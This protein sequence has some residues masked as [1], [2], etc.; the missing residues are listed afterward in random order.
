MLSFCLEQS[1]QGNASALARL[2]GGHYSQIGLYLGQKELPRFTSLLGLCFAL[3]ISP[4][5]FLTASPSHPTK[6]LASK[7]D[8]LPK[9]PHKGKQPLTSEARELLKQSLDK[10]LIEDGI[11]L[12]SLHQVSSRLGLADFTIRKYCPDQCDKLTAYWR[13]WRSDEQQVFLRQALEEA[14]TSKEIVSLPVVLQ[15]IGCSRRQAYRYCPDLCEAI[16]RRYRDQFDHPRIEQALKEALTKDEPQS[17]R[18]VARQLGYQAAYIWYPFRNLCRQVSARYS[19][20]QRRQAEQHYE[21]LCQEVRAAVVALDQQGIYPSAPQ[22]GK[23][24]GNPYLLM[25]SDMREIWHA[26]LEE[27]GYQ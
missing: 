25:R 22:V 21:G 10:V 1:M 23:R 15:H 9:I 12:P 6:S 7:L 17:V 19:A 16:S 2:T 26:T 13:G 27:L 14:L 20:K 5:E 18:E 24:L 8:Q 11:P 3:K 4:V